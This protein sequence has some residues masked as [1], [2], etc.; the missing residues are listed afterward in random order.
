MCRRF[1]ATVER[2]F[3]FGG[4][5]WERAFDQLDAAARWW[6]RQSDRRRDS[7]KLVEGNTLAEGSW[8]A[9][10]QAG[11]LMHAANAV[12]LSGDHC[13]SLVLAMMAREEIGRAN[14]LRECALAANNGKRFTVREIRERTKDHEEKQDRGAPGVYLQPEAGTPLYKAMSEQSNLACNSSEWLNAE[15]FI[16]QEVKRIEKNQP[17]KRHRHRMRAMYVD[18]SRDGRQWLRPWTVD[19]VV[20]KT[21][22]SNAASDY[23]HSTGNR[24]CVELLRR[25]S[26]QP[27]AQFMLAHVP[28]DMQLPGPVLLPP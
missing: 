10:E 8:Y 20:A 5:L 18:L 6:L 9:I 25:L 13:S 16:Q 2:M 14:I 4:S 24:Y 17:E 28:K 21:E 19:K 23:A 7:S 26:G 11:R 12:F 3:A 1:G 22:I 15:V 27:D